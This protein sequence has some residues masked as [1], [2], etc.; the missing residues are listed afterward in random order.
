MPGDRLALSAAQAPRPR[1]LEHP[2]RAVRTAP[3]AQR[4]GRIEDAL[5]AAAGEPH[6]HL[7][8]RARVDGGRED[9]AVLARE[10]KGEVDQAVGRQ[11]RP[12]LQDRTV[13]ATEAAGGGDPHLTGEAAGHRAE[14]TQA[15]RLGVDQ[16]RPRRTRRIEGGDARGEQHQDAARADRDG[17]PHLLAWLP[18]GADG[19]PPVA[20]V[21]EDAF[22]DRP[23]LAAGDGVDARHERVG[24]AAHPRLGDRLDDIAVEDVDALDQ[25]VTDRDAPVRRRS[26]LARV[27]FLQPVGRRPVAPAGLRLRRRARRRG[28]AERRRQRGRRTPRES[29][30]GR[31]EKSGETQRV[32][33]S[34]IGG[35]AVMHEAH[36]ATSRA[37]PCRSDNRPRCAESARLRR[38]VPH[39]AIVVSRSWCIGAEAPWRI[40][41][42]C[43]SRARCA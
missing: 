36:P 18:P 26:E 2:Q 6:R 29:G 15:G 4:L 10:R 39:D 16:R 30:P 35:L 31:A 3:G 37:R 7:V 12:V 33:A 27:R 19:P 20:E 5:V 9:L 14:R 24:V 17:A 43:P 41:R 34:A 13:E 42:A 38:F 11:R 32:L 28:E 21:L 8:A 40:V 25:A 1:S 22:G 23:R